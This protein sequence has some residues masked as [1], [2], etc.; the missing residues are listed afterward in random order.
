MANTRANA[1]RNEGDNV[2]QEVSL[3]VRPQAPIDHTRENV[4]NAEFRLA[5]EMLAQAMTAQ[6]NREVVASL[7]PNVNSTALRV[8]DFMRMNPS[9]FYGSKVEKVP[10]GFKDEI[11]KLLSI[12]GVT[13]VEKVKLATYQLK[14]IAQVWHEQWKDTRPVG[15]GPIEWE[16]FKLEFLERFFP[17]KLREDKVEEFINLRQGSM[18]LKGYALNFT[19]LSKYSP[20]IVADEG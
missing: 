18:S 6:V 2:E 8:R 14:D 20:T 16:V 9:E 13:S 10:K 11:Y 5:I 17:Q 4:T 15:V 19:E 3:Q 1:R 12:M 7:N